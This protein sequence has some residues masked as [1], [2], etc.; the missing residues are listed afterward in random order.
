MSRL[1]TF[2]PIAVITAALNYVPIVYAQSDAD[3]APASESPVV[4]V[5]TATTDDVETRI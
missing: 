4:S 3:Q 1:S 5:A 2:V